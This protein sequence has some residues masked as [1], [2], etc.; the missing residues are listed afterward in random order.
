MTR[1][2]LRLGALA[3]SL[4][5]AA[6]GG[7]QSAPERSLPWPGSAATHPGRG[8]SHLTISRDGGGPPR[9]LLVAQADGRLL[10]ISPRGQVVWHERQADPGAVFVSRTGRTEIIT[11]PH[12]SRV[13][14]RRIDSGTVAFVYGRN[15][16]RLRAP[17]SAVEDAR[18]EVV[19]ADTGNCRL[20]FARQTSERPL[21]VIA[22]ARGCPR[23]AL[24]GDGLLVVTEQGPVGIAVLSERGAQLARIPLGDLTVPSD[25]VAF[26]AHAIVVADQ[27][28]PGRVVEIDWRGRT[29]WSYGPPAGP[30]EL[31]R[32]SLASVLPDGNVLV[33][34]GGNDRVVVIDRQTKLIVW[35]YGHRGVAG[36]RPGYLERPTSAT[37]VPLGGR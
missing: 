18:G 10:S 33:L 22:W 7:T 21:R 31:D 34:D 2:A 23:S 37:L 3:L 6:C 32:P 13:V 14:L 35:Q 19:I 26:R 30:G 5:L 9:N 24:I 25:A 20:V 1:R 4:A 17:G 8:P 11:Q 36:N 15:R 12:A 27:T 29:L 16:L 28:K